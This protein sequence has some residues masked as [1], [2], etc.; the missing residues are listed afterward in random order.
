MQDSQVKVSNGCK[1]NILDF[2]LPYV[3]AE[4]VMKPGN[5]QYKWFGPSE[6]Y[7]AGNRKYLTLAISNLYRLA[8][9]HSPQDYLREVCGLSDLCIPET[10]EGQ[11]VQSCLLAI[12]SCLNNVEAFF[13][14]KELQVAISSYLLSSGIKDGYIDAI[15]LYITTGTNAPV[16]SNLRQ[17]KCETFRTIEEL[18]Q[19]FAE[20]MESTK[21]W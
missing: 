2:K 3:W 19:A 10:D 13:A 18:R 17:S 9:G 12:Q 15:W 11:N 7:N 14:S 5:T 1:S 6:D 8:E 4:M 16:I 20:H 21:L